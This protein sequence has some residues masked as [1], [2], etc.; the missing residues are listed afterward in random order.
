[1]RRQAEICFSFGRELPYIC[2]GDVYTYVYIY[3]QYP[4][5]LYILYICEYRWVYCG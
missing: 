4:E 2:S 1:M 5:I 3:I